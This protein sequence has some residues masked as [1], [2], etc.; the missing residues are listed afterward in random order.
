M[1][2]FMAIVA[3][4]PD[5][6][7]PNRRYELST[8]LFIALAATLCGGESCTDMAEFAKAKRRLLGQFVPLEKG[9]P[10][11]D[12]FSRLFALLDPERF[13]P[14]LREFAAAFAGQLR[15]VVALDGKSVRRAFGK[16][17]A[18]SPLHLVCAY[19]A[20]SRL[21]LA[22]RK[23]PERNEAAALREVLS[24][25]ALKGCTVTA[26]ALFCYPA[27]AE[28]IRAR[29]ADYAIA[30]KRN[31]GP[32]WRAAQARFAQDPED[33][34]EFTTADR[35]HGRIEQRTAR[36]IAV[37]DLAHSFPDLAAIGRIVASRTATGRTTVDTRYFLLSRILTPDQLIE[38]V[39]AHWRIEN[40]L[41]WVL[42]VVFDE[43]RARN[44]IDHG[45]ENLAILR[46][47]ALNTLRTDTSK[48]SLRVK[49]K[50]AG[51]DDEF[52]VSILSHMR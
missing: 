15:G 4:V 44:R 40:S 37:P 28:A 33:A 17:G 14:A 47:L 48:G 2:R 12:T 34:D 27:M 3:S 22:Q 46:R 26:D 38:T 49:I 45:P 36:V 5:P 24:L 29:G 1:D 50:R 9:T 32:L 6:R 51:W 25:L 52:F 31:H 42:D 8:I 41:H 19:A 16:E 13:E 23:A 7:K 30:L 20:E 11:H 39:R 18:K 35:A 21:V 10:S 43:D